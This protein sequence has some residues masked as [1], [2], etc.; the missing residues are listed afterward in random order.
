M[1]RVAGPDGE[2]RDVDEEDD[3]RDDPQHIGKADRK[4]RVGGGDGPGPRQARQPESHTEDARR[5]PLWR[6]MFRLVARRVAHRIWAV[7]AST[8]ALAGPGVAWRKPVPAQ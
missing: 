1:H 3:G 2:P 5:H 4:S 6:R 8:M 7:N